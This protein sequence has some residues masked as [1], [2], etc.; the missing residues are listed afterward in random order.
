[1]KRQSTHQVPESRAPFIDG[2]DRTWLF[3]G[4][5]VLLAIGVR[6]L[7]LYELQETPFFAGHFSDSKIYLHLADQLRGE[8]IP[9]AYFMSPLYPYLIAI[10]WSVTDSPEFWMRMLQVLFGAA[11][12][13]CT[14]LLG[15][16][17]FGHST[18][19]VAA[20]I[21]ALYAPLIYYDGLLL[22]ESLLTL[23]LTGHMFVLVGA[24]KGGSIRLWI[25]AGILLGLAA[26]T[27]ATAALFP[28]ALLLLW[29]YSDS[30]SR[31]ART[32][33]VA[34]VLIAFMMLLPTTIRNAGVEGVFLP[35]TSS[36]GF[37]LHAGNN[38]DATGQYS[39]PEKIDILRDPGG[40]FW[41]EQQ[42]GR[43]VNAAEASA[44]W[45]SRAM[46]WMTAHPGEAVALYGRKLL[47]FFHP[48]EIDQLGL[49]LRFFNREFASVP[50]IPA[51]AFPL[52]FILFV[53]G[54]VSTERKSAV[55]WLPV[56]FIFIYVLATA[57]F[58]VSARLRLP[59][60]R[61]SY[62]MH[63]SRWSAS[64]SDCVNEDTGNSVFPSS[65]E[66]VSQSPY[67]F[68]SPECSRCSNRSI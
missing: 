49:S 30:D 5:S 9:H 15:R 46:D 58:F 47:L 41:I 6:L 54:V 20:L 51:A 57:V 25:V 40:K 32:G 55:S 29:L 22:T 66:V 14:Y 65:S 31:P 53:I 67:C 3:A 37:N 39:M 26:I 42:T 36:F 11:T 44:Y 23:L 52:L 56:L 16:K 34:Y 59:S 60:C 27:R 24:W 21:V 62:C 19:A 68:C 61:W 7:F 4:L 2:F 10:V 28:F 50:G 43:A 45:R 13:L 63:P 8:G 38:P 35:V 1:M 48:E 18:A 33:L 12:T 17:L 64:C